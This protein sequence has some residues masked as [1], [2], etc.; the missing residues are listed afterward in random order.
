MIEALAVLG[1]LVLTVAAVCAMV[2]YMRRHPISR[3]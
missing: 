2:W 1:G 3:P